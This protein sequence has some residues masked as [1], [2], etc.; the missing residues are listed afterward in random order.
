[1]VCAVRIV[2][3]YQKRNK[4]IVNEK[5]RERRERNKEKHL[6]V[7]RAWAKKNKEKIKEQMRVWREKNKDRLKEYDEKTRAK[8]NAQTRVWAKRNA[9]RKKATDKRYQ[10]KM[11]ATVRHK[12][13]ARMAQ[14]IRHAI[15]AE[16]AG[17][18]WKTLV[19][20][21]WLEL[22]AH[23]EKKFKDGMSWENIGAWHIDHIL[24]ISSFS[25]TKAEDEEFKRCWALSN[26]QPLWG[27]EN[28][29]KSDKHPLDWN[30]QKAGIL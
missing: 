10:D 7:K 26:L 30:I 21:N 1:M 22:K 12:L 24:P 23:L 16:K 3:A 2:T 14:H 29:R 4:K 9:A 5:R 13:N 18:T 11:R 28:V 17:R 19:G 27:S 8:H 20:Y 15:K 25:F 6:K